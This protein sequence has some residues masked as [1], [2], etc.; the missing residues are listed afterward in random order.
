M[1]VQVTM[2]LGGWLMLW[3]GA[4]TPHVGKGHASENVST[5]GG[6]SVE[7]MDG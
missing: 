1:G 5:I 3:L 2:G 7:G 6:R 4:V